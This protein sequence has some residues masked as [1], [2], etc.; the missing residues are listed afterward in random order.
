MSQTMM[1]PGPP[2]P[3]Q[4]PMPVPQGAVPN[5]AYQQWMQAT[6]ARQQIIQANVQKQAQFEAACQLIRSDG[7]RG[8]KLDIEADST[9]A[10]DE[11]AEKQARI[12][13]LQQI[14]P[15]IEQGA[16]VAQ[17]NPKMAALFSEIAM[18][19]VR[20]FRVA[21]PLEEAFEQA[22]EV[23]GQMPPPPP[24]GG[25]GTPPPDPALE[26]ARVMAQVHDTQAKTQAA[27]QDTQA[28]TQSAQSVAA[29]KAQTDQ[30]A[31]AQKA[32]QAAM[33]YQ[34]EQQRNAAQVQNDQTEAAIAMAKLAS[35]ERIA[36]ARVMKMGAQSAEGLT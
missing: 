30:M 31:I 25:H 3:S 34:S 10:P 36:N 4:G 6:Q 16:P 2:G 20:G 19:A 26:Q 7:I 11:Q 18:F 24:K 15:L 5:P 14:V 8:F 17:G 22:F 9:I 13:F 33:Q 29:A 1:P 27:M 32:Q 28:R 21:R 23:L 12:E 35:A